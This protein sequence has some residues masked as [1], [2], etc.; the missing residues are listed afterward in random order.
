MN[1][2]RD[3]VSISGAG[4]LGGGTYE[5]VSISGAGKVTGDVVA[6]E[7][8]IS[9][10]GKVDGRTEAREIT[11]SGSAT[12]GD[13]VTAEEMGVSGS[14]RVEGRLEAKE[15]K[16]SGTCRVKG[17]ISSEY[18]KSTGQLRVGGDLESAIFKAT[19]GFHIGGL[20]SA[21]KIDVRLGGRCE[22]REIGGETIEIRRG[23][24]K[25]KGLIID[26]LVKLFFGGGIAEL[27]TEQIEGDDIFLEDTTAE[28][29]RGKRIKI[30]PGCHIGTVEYEETLEVDPDAEVKRHTKV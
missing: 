24:W 11:A 6:D 10:V 9:G 19:G 28:I 15:L 5:R 30:G 25:E 2:K 8:R 23:G 26:G 22:A 1:E 14:S 20:L 3:S 13:S 18:V 7:I 27:R 17:S 16:C 12:F 29:V 21:D 4:K